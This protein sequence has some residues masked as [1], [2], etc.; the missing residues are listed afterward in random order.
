MK[1]SI[2]NLRI[3]IFLIA[4]STL[5]LELSLIRVFDVILTPNMGYAVIT[6]AVFALGLGGIYLYILPVKTEKAVRNTISVL[7]IAFAICVLVLRPV[8]NELPFNL[9][10]TESIPIQVFGWLGMYLALVVPFFLSGLIISLMLS[11]YSTQVHS[12]YFFDLLGAAIGCLLI[13][14]LITDYGPGGIQFIV[15]G[16]AFLGGSVFFGK[17]SIRLALGLIAVICVAYPATQDEYLEYRGHANKRNVDQWTKSGL[18]D[19]VIWDPVSKVEVFRSRPEALNFA[20]DGGQQGSWL[21][22]FDGNFDVFDDEKEKNP[23]SYY[24]GLNSVVHYLKDK[25]NPEVLV[26]GAAV[27]GEI[28]SALAFG[29]KKVDGVEL[30]SEMVDVARTRYSQY[31][32]GVFTHPKVNYYASEGRTYLR[33]TRKQY[34]IIQMFSNHTSSSMADGSA[35]APAAYLQTVEAYV[36]YFTHL[37]NDGVMQ[38]NHHIYPRM[39]T[40]AAKAW[41]RL[42]RSDFSRHVLVAERWVPDN[43]PTMLIKMQPWTHGEVQKVMSYLNRKHH[44]Y[45]KEVPQELTLSDLVTGDNPYH[46]SFTAPRQKLERLR[47]WLGTHHQQR[48]SYDI[49]LVLSS[50]GGEILAQQRLSG[51]EIRDNAPVELFFDPPL[52]NHGGSQLTLSL[53]AEQANAENGFIV[54]S[55]RQGGPQIDFRGEPRSFVLVFDPSN[56]DSNLIPARLLDEDFPKSRI[57]ESQYNFSPATDNNPYFSMIRRTFGRVNPATSPFLDGGTAWLLNA[58]LGKIVSAEWLNLFIVG[59]ISI[60]FSGVFIFL[61]LFY[62]KRGCARWPGMGAYLAY[63]SCLGAGF[64]LVELVL[65]QLFKKLIGYP[66]HTFATVLFALLVSAG[67]GSLMTKKLKIDTGNRWRLVFWGI[68]LYGGILTVSAEAIFYFFL[69]YSTPIRIAVAVVILLPLGFGMGMPLPIGVAR[70][71]KVQSLGIPWAWGMNGFFTVFGG[72]LSVLLSV[73]FGFKIVLLTGFSIYLL[74]MIMYGRIRLSEP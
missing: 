40:T 47:F 69:S 68:A 14:P 23:N 57:P 31:S 52:I 34:D 54:W 28:R 36:E 22:K 39:L 60:V 19:Y 9:E 65:I 17:T 63:F 5:A 10:V 61:P 62:S 29:A 41:R 67:I 49:N 30:V 48:L 74:G 16:M 72:F 12:L 70:L 1:L 3:G 15:A 6:A 7:Y 73:Q 18:R 37:T 2:N 51:R 42:G 59:F 13:V 53:T 71:G 46:G 55:H 26:I 24:F 44:R 56:P 21:T 32:G 4:C 50:V 8:I 11:N 43:L 64:I 33:S 66:I 38:I 58:Q 20:L 45:T 35:A 25:S 27:G